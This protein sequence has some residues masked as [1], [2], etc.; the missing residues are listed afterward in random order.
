MRHVDGPHVKL[1][2]KGDYMAKSVKGEYQF[3]I[4]ML[5]WVND[6]HKEFTS[7]NTLINLNRSTLRDIK[8]QL[9]DVMRY[10][11]RYLDIRGT[12]SSGGLSNK[13]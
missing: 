10:I 3:D 12:Q 11:D 2:K 6:V 7:K 8:F 9:A 1:L 4:T 5:S 13:D